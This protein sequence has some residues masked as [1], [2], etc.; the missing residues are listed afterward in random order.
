MIKYRIRPGL[1]P[2]TRIDQVDIVKET[3]NWVWDSDDK[4]HSRASPY[5]SFHDTWEAARASLL[6]DAQETLDNARSA[7]MRAQGLHGNIKGLREP[8]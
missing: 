8:S 4:R 1:W 2:S 6:Q 7:L 3:G 5:S